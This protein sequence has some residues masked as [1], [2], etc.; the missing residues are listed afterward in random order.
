MSQ[1]RLI[2]L[3]LILLVA[4]VSAVEVVKPAMDVVKPIP[5]PTPP[6]E[7]PYKTKLIIKPKFKH[8]KLKPG[9]SESFDVE[10]KNPTDKDVRIEPRIFEGRIGSI[11][12][13]W[14]SF[15]K[16][17][18][19]L[20]SKDSATIIVTVSVPND[21]EKGFYSCRILFTNDSINSIYLSIEVFIPPSVKI[22]PR[23]IDDFV[24]AGKT[25]E[26]KVK[27]KNKGSETFNLNPKVVQPSVSFEENW[28][29]EKEI[30]I[31]SPPTIPPNSEVEV[32]IVVNVPSDAS[33]HLRG[34]ID[35]GIDDP[36][37]YEWGRR[38]ELSLNVYRAPKEPFVKI[39]NI[40]NASKLTIRVSSEIFKVP[41]PIPILRTSTVNDFDVRI[42]SPSGDVKIKPKIVESLIV[43]TGFGRP[44]WEET[45]GIYKVISTTK[46]KIYEI[47]NPENGVWRIEVMPKGC[48]GF[49]LEVEIE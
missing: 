31:S 41:I 2:P 21:A 30:T 13:N 37:L 23:W 5:P 11:D 33:G 14:I 20:K 17:S 44:P 9:Q 46:K 47:E 42:V 43:T 7:K 12:I 34:T 35:L 49:S 39:L 18:F 25:Y 38:V 10:I 45:E 3:L 32:K 24:E 8:L 28:L 1:M 36:G 19:I 26:Y 27:V 4:S 22:S 15:D 48:L 40:D 29:S 16:E 6:I